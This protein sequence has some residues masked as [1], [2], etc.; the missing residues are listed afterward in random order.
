MPDIAL[1]IIIP[2]HRRPVL[3]ARA[4]RSALLD[5]NP[6]TEVIVVED[7]DNSAAQSLAEWENEPRLK[8]MRNDGP[9]GASA[10]RNYG[11]ARAR[12]DIILFLD[13]DDELI[14]DYIGRFMPIA[15]RGRANWGFARQ[16]IRQANDLPLRPVARQG[17]V[18][19]L[20]NVSVLFHRKMAA[21]SSGFWVR[22]DLFLRLGGLCIEQTLD[23]DTDLCCRLLAAGH[24]PW[25]DPEPAIILDRCIATQR[26]T[27]DTDAKTRAA[28]YLRTFQRNYQTLD[29]EARAIP[30]LSFR[31][32]RMILRS[33]QDD[34]LSE[35]YR[36]VPGIGLKAALR[37]K[38]LLNLISKK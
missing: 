9:G 15:T 37:A 25:F 13:D 31:A 14:S 28:C 33:G 7:R 16:L 36:N 24:Q 3:V 34:L 19:G 1:S 30:Y 6:S 4:V 29:V 26:L 2:T 32:Q 21:L 23:E 10:T 17:W 18:G 8:L 5:A 35:L 12:G 22:R 27:S 11:V 38:R 20:P